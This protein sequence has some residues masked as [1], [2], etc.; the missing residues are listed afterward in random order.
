M[1]ISHV[2]SVVVMAY[3]IAIVDDDP[4]LLKRVCTL[5]DREARRN[6]WGLTIHRF[7]SAEEME[8]LSYLVEGDDRK[9]GRKYH[10][11]SGRQQPLSV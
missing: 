3:R 9:R 1:E 6:H 11:L 4:A 10:Q 2:E 8:T 5:T 7:L